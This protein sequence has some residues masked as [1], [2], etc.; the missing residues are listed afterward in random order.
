MP[1]AHTDPWFTALAPER[2]EALIARG[3]ERRA[4]P[5]TRVYGLGDPP[6]GLW[7]VREGEVRLVSYPALGVESLALILGPGAWFGE[8]SVID[9]GPRPH[10]AVVVKP[11]R[12]LHVTLAAIEQ[13][14]ADHPLLYRD[15][16]ALI[17]SR[18]RA[19]LGALGRIIAQPIGVRLAR[20]LAGLAHASGGEEVQMRQDDLAAMVGV[21]R[22]TANKALK[23]LEASG[24]IELRY[25][26][27]VVLEPAR[28]RLAGQ[29]EA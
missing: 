15:L 26:R 18:Q 6:D 7:C 21:S 12:L 29:S 10:D 19:T 25:G 20:T 14:A 17:C 9:G 11:A 16:G 2:R 4:A 1:G 22:Q 24:A 27:I 5:G 3:H 23:S 28:L 8:L 13:I